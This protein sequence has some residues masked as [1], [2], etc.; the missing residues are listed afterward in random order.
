LQK[1]GQACP[2]S[3]PQRHHQSSFECSDKLTS[4]SMLSSLALWL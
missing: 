2:S 4:D 1:K 3:R